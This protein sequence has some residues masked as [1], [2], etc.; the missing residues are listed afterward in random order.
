MKIVCFVTA[1]ILLMGSSAYADLSTSELERVQ[2]ATEVVSALRQ[3]PDRGIP[4]DLW[5]KAECVI[6]MPSVKKAAF[7]VGGEFGKGVMSCRQGSDWTAPVFMEMG[8]GSIGFQIGAQATDLVLLVMNRQ[9]VNRMLEDHVTLG[10][11]ASVA[12]GP[13]GRTGAA[14]TD[15]KFTAEVLSYSRSKGLFAGIDVSGGVLRPDKDSNEHAYGTGTTA[16]AVAT[17]GAAT[18]AQ[19]Q[20]FVTA[21]G[22]GTRAT[23][24]RR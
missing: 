13:V 19:M 24:G 12:A 4:E 6:V 9:G 16:K 5:G 23:T 17:S 7:G 18:P 3:A 14:A 11:D 1:V 2:K 21:L 8:K 22:S 10:T 15:H 20:A